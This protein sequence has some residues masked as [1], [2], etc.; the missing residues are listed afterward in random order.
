MNFVLLDKLGR[1]I[2]Y[3]GD[4]SDDEVRSM[5]V[6]GVVLGPPKR[7]AGAQKSSQH[8]IMGEFSGYKLE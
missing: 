7:G 3:E 1:P 6:A 8:V 5:V 2:T 4:V